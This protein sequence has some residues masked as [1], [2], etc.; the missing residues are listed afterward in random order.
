MLRKGN[1]ITV[2]ETAIGPREKG[3]EA[4][5]KISIRKSN[6]AGKV[7]VTCTLGG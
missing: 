7:Q 4:R 6:T 2:D 3:L 1:T 5:G